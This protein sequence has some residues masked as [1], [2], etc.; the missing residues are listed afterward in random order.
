MPYSHVGVPLLLSQHWSAVQPV[1][2][3][4]ATHA[5]LLQV[6]VPQFRHVCAPVPHWV[7]V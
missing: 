2:D 7:F 1:H 4:G 6:L 5:P 3:G